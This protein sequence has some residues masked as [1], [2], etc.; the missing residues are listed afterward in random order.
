M[1]HEDKDYKTDG[2]GFSRDVGNT[3]SY[4]GRRVGEEQT[5]SYST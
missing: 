3:S 2:R 1:E 5:R 4:R